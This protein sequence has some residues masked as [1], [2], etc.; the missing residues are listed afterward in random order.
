VL[1]NMHTCM[2]GGI[3]NSAFGMDPPSL[4]D[5]GSAA[6]RDAR[7]QRGGERLVWLVARGRGDGCVCWFVALIVGRLA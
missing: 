3:I 6:R 2:Y 1:T 7:I 5:W 4:A